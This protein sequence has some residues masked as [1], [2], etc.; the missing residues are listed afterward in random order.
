MG[1]ELDDSG[2][3]EPDAA[4]SV[5]GIDDEAGVLYNPL[6]IVRPVVG[7]DDRAVCLSQTIFHVSGNDTPGMK[8]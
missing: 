6:P 2:S 1:L 3:G 4:G 8:L 5:A 7:D